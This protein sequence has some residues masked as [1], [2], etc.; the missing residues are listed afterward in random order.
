MQHIYKKIKEALAEIYPDNETV[1]LSRLIIEHISGQSFT[2]FLS[3]KNNK[4]TPAQ[5]EKIDHII[6]R[7]ITHEPIQYILG[8]TEFFGLPFVV[9]E[10]V[11][12]PRP[13]TEE[14]VETILSEHKDSKVKILDIGTGSGSIAIALKKYLPNASIEAWDFSEKA[15]DTARLN[16]KKNNTN[17]VFKKVDV[18]SDYPETEKF[19]IIVS[20]PPYV[21]ESEK[22]VMN[23]NVLDY[24][25]YSAL[26]VPDNNPL[27]FYVRI[28]DIA[29]K[30][31]KREGKIYL[32]INQ[33][34][35]AETKQMLEEKKFKNVV[36]IKDISGN[37]RIIKADY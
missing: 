6:E 5:E 19:D 33:A 34:K 4:I 2:S 23:E 21:L 9:N 15:L 13:E 1:S 35:G 11:L 22:Q 31:L 25:P 10:N 36:I 14:L 20:N 7:L 16:A 17:I 18:L 26:F 37:D 32:E 29:T 27:L 28:A 24:E 30:L 12:I 3:D 8:E